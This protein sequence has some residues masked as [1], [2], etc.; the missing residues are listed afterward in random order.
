MPFFGVLSA[1]RIHSIIL[2]VRFLIFDSFITQIISVYMLRYEV[3][4]GGTKLGEIDGVHQS[5][6]DY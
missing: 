1:T 2:S 4:M 5:F 3:V 6:L